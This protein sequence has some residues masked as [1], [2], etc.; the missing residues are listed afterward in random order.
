[1]GVSHSGPRKGD[2]T[3]IDKWQGHEQRGT[4]HTAV[5]VPVLERGDQNGDCI[6][7]VTPFGPRNGFVTRTKKGKKSRTARDTRED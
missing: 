7:S 4:S 5:L 2:K 6:A 3:K 1:M